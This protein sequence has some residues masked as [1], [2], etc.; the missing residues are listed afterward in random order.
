MNKLPHSEILSERTTN[1]KRGLDLQRENYKNA[2]VLDN[3]DA[4]AKILEN[5]KCE[6]KAKAV[7]KN[8]HGDIIRIEK[9]LK[10]YNTLDNQYIQKTPS[11]RQVI[12]PENIR[13]KIF[14]NLNVAYE[15][16]MKILNALQLL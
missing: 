11:G 16:C 6:I 10:W 12:F 3:T 1:F 8:M 15:L 7:K 13:D 4:M 2:H 9:I 5:I 14:S